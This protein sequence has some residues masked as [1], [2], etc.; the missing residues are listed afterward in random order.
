M[1][2]RRGRPDPHINI[3]RVG[4]HAR[5]EARPP[6]DNKTMNLVAK[7]ELKSTPEQEEVLRVTLECFNE[8]CDFLAV[9]AWQT[10]QI[11]TIRSVHAGL[12]RCTQDVRPDGASH[13]ALHR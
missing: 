2:G 5:E 1:S 10:S 9:K 8:A 6:V 12:P 3:S 11:Q 13:R 4:N 7:L